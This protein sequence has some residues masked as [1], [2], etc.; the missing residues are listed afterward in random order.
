MMGRT[1]GFL[2]E[3]LVGVGVEV[4]AEV[5][6]ARLHLGRA[7]GHVGDGHPAQ[8]V[9]VDDLGPAVAVLLAGQRLVAVEPHHP[10]VL[11]GL[12]LRE[13]ERSRAHP[14]RDPLVGRELL[15]DLLRIDRRHVVR[16]GE[17]DEHDAG[18]LL[19]LHLDGVLVHHLQVDHL[20]KERLAVDGALAPAHERRDHVV[21][22]HLLA[23][24]EA[25]A[26]SELEGV[27]EPVLGDGVAL[28][29]HGDGLIALVERVEA[30][31][32]MVRQHL[33]DGLGAPVR[34]ERGWLAEVT[35]AQ[36]AALFR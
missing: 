22:G 3:A 11:V 15:G 31:E 19:E 29:Q 34:V 13:L 18:L 7:A 2:A 8:L 35:D 36:H 1:F 21:R 9:D 20:R 30:L 6:V 12:P 27:D 17:R 25:D 5:E 28:G 24:V 4:V 32:D 10:D 14:L 33:G 16:H 26:L 23:V